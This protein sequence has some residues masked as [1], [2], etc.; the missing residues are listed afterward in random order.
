MKPKVHQMR[1][2]SRVEAYGTWDATQMVNISSDGKIAYINNANGSKK[3]HRKLD[4]GRCD[5]LNPRSY[6]FI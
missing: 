2:M 1:A 6:F 3:A 5:G 4:Q